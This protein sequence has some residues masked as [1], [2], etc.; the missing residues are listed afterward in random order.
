MA[1]QKQWWATHSLLTSV[2][3][4][5]AVLAATG[6]KTE[7]TAPDLPA[8][9][10]PG[11]KLETVVRTGSD[12]IATYRATGTAHLRLHSIHGQAEGL[13]LTQKWAPK[14]NAVVFYGERYFAVLDWDT[15][16]RDQAAALVRTLERRIQ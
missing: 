12:W 2:L 15:V 1:K 3:V 9:V 11:W 10:S 7:T 14:P 8:S 6:C 16:E 4:A 5:S 13:D